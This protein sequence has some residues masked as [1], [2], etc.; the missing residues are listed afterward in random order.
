M[1][2]MSWLILND[3][4]S[5]EIICNQRVQ[6]N[7]KESQNFNPRINSCKTKASKVEFIENRI[8]VKIFIY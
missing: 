7:K 4:D 6:N 3:I 1:D 5:D 8:K 2:M